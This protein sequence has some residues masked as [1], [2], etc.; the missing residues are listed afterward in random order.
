[1]VYKMA[2]LTV[3][4]VLFVFGLAGVILRAGSYRLFVTL[5]F[6]LAVCTIIATIADLYLLHRYGIIRQQLRDMA[7]M[8]TKT[9]M[10]SRYSVDL[11]AAMFDKPEKM[12]HLGCV[13]VTI[14]NLPQINQGAGHVAGDRVISDFC[15]IFED[16][17]MR[18]GQIGR[19]GGNEYLEVIERCDH[20][21]VDLFLSDLEKR[22]R[23]HN[24]QESDIPIELT[25]AAVLNEEAGEERF[26]GLIAR[27]YAK[28]REGAQQ[29]I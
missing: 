11:M 22:V 7:V 24:E 20:T 8:D 14:D 9:G 4:A 6:A 12:K 13:L 2:L 15:G 25:Y 17:G 10:P 23:L 26:F 19:N 1:M 29:L 28:F 16:V 3:I 27:T 5:F 21:S 18:Y